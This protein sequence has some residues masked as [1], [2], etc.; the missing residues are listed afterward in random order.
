MKIGA[1]LLIAC[2]VCM[3]CL[4]CT[5]RQTVR[6]QLMTGCQIINP[7]QEP[8]QVLRYQ[9]AEN[10]LEKLSCVNNVTLNRTIPGYASMSISPSVDQTF[11]LKV[12]E[13]QPDGNTV[14]SFVIDNLHFTDDNL[15]EFSRQV[16]D[17]LRDF[18]GL[19]GTY[20]MSPTGVIN[21]VHFNPQPELT[22]EQFKRITHVN[23]DMLELMTCRLPNEPIG[24]GAQW[25]YQIGIGNEY[26]SVI[27]TMMVTLVGFDG[28]QLQLKLSHFQTLTDG[29]DYEDG[30]TIRIKRHYVH[31]FGAWRLNRSR[32]TPD[33]YMHQNN[34]QEFEI[35]KGA[36]KASLE[37]QGTAVLEIHPHADI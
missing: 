12:R 36:S 15:P 20:V 23:K 14:V 2:V 19:G 6:Q 13:I 24:K 4:G 33:L 28:D 30:V 21:Q 8:R 11:V 27:Q 32:I 26:F 9:L 7:G 17:A 25:K 10:Q 29:Y 1:H 18:K 22:D 16:N 34:V 31:G 35:K 3:F 5:E 37:T